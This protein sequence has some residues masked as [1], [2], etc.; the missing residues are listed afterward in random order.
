MKKSPMAKPRKRPRN[1]ERS[2]KR[3]RSR[4]RPFQ[5]GKSGNPKGRPPIS[6]E[7]KAAMSQLEPDALEG[8]A[9]IV[10]DRRHPQRE[11]AIEYVINRNRGKPTERREISGPG[12]EPVEKQFG[13]ILAAFTKLAGGE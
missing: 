11:K 6:P 2:A 7:Y 9:E 12:G 10:R 8:L 4:G 3:L 1:S 13:E 5:K